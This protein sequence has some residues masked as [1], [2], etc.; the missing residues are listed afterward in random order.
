MA[1]W[2]I[3][4]EWDVLSPL[5]D[6][7]IGVQQAVGDLVED[8]GLPHPQVVD[9]VFC[10]RGRRRQGQ[11][12]LLRRGPG[13][14]LDRGGQADPYQVGGYGQAGQWVGGFVIEAV[15]DVLQ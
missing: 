7:G 10:R 13:L 12:L 3:W 6:L 14:E 2:E 1:Q 15:L 5:Q 9:V 4:S 11:A 8:Q